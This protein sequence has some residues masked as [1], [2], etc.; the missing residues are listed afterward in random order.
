M[1][2]IAEEWLNSCSGCEIALLNIGEVL[3][4]LLPSLDF[5]HIPVLT[6][7]KYYGAL[8]TGAKLTIPKADVGIVSGG[9]RNAEHLEVLQEMRDKCGVLVALGSCATLGGL[10]ALSDFPGNQAIRDFTYRG[11]PSTEPGP[12]PDP[13]RF[14]IPSL[15]KSCD[16]LHEHVKVDLMLPGCPP[17]PDWIAEAILAL[18]EGH[19]P[20]FPDRALCD[21]CPTYRTGK[22]SSETVNRLLKQPTFD[23]EQPL[24]KMQCLLEQGF[25][26]MGPVTRAGCGGRTGA[27]RCIQG[28]SPCEGCYG[29][30]R[31]TSK[32]IADYVA[33]MAA[34]GLNAAEMPDK[35]GFL[36]RFTGAPEL[37]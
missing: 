17:A 26:C 20:V 9:V 23:P 27:P 24:E 14:H 3:V 2:K 37:P 25:M 19:A 8:G 13:T 7:N 22:K 12:D 6:D 33:A 15:L 16:P 28:R 4:D 18:L 32:P 35:P 30:V 21:V 31:E 29:P 36:T 5:V 10:P 34:V 11:S 1:V